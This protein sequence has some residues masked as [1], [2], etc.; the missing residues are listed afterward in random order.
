VEKGTLVL[1]RENADLLSEYRG[2]VI[3]V[4]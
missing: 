2:P 4:P 1:T 3:L